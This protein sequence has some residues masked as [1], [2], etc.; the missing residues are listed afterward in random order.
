MEA[1]L[2]ISGVLPDEDGGKTDLATL[3]KKLAEKAGPRRDTSRQSSAKPSIGTESH[4]STPLHHELYSSPHTSVP[5]PG[6]ERSKG[7]EKG[8]KEKEKEKGKET[9]VEVLSDMMCSLVTNNCGETRYIG[10][11]R[12]DLVDSREADS[13]QDH[14][15]GF[16]SFPR[17]VSSGLVK[18]LVT[19]H[20]RT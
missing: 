8:K 9:E 3:E 19:V 4:H 7:K 10:T 6:S 5:S 13:R 18:R 11:R 16:P 17:K 2:K 15:Q 12:P 14:R 20:F 1:L